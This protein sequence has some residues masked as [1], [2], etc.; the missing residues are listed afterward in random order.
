MRKKRNQKK[1]GQDG[2]GSFA[3]YPSIIT[4]PTC[5]GDRTGH[6]EMHIRLRPTDGRDGAAAGLAP[7]FS[8]RPKNL[9]VDMGSLRGPWG[10]PSRA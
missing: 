6:V 7:N 3:S 2:V 10:A 8:L 1:D 4:L 9:G 5:Q